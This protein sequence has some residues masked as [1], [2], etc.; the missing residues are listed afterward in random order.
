M[1]VRGGWLIELDIQT[2]FDSICQAQLLEIIRKRVGD[3][4]WLRHVATDR[5]MVKRR[6]DDKKRTSTLDIRN[7]AGWGP[8]SLWLRFWRIFFFTKSWT[9]G[10]RMT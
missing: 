10:L 4:D 2:Y 1:A 6:C 5:K 8:I 9:N 7:T 3:G